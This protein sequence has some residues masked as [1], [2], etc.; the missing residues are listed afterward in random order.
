MNRA[1]KVGC[2]AC[3]VVPVLLYCVVLSSLYIR[4]DLK[5]GGVVENLQLVRLE[6][7][8]TT[9]KE[10]ENSGFASARAHQVRIQAGTATY[11]EWNHRVYCGL[12]VG[13]PIDVLVLFYRNGALRINQTVAW[14]KSLF[15]AGQRIEIDPETYARIL[16]AL[17]HLP[18]DLSIDLY[19][20]NVLTNRHFFSV[21]K[22]DTPQGTIDP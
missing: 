7:G 19:F 3:I 9:L 21:G 4:D 13:D 5:L 11:F 14:R 16:D 18:E 20:H 17:G 8:R 22:T 12:A 6:E 2:L 15:R 10:F 1:F